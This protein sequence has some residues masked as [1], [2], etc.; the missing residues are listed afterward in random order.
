MA[1]IGKTPTPAP[2]TSSDIAADII[3]STHIGD[4][5]ISGF[6]AL[7][8]APADTDEFLI[9]DAGVLKRLDASLV[10]GG[11]KVLQVVTATASSTPSTTSSSFVTTG[12]SLSITPSA[13]SSK[14]FLIG[15][16][17]LQSTGNSVSVDIHQST[18]SSFVSGGLARGIG[19][20]EPANVMVSCS[21]NVLVSPNTTSAITYTVYFA[22]NGGSTAYYGRNDLL[23]SLTAFEIGA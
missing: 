16:F 6:D 3:N 21:A 19:A 18:S 12:H 14:I 4:T 1:Y 8:T 11:G 2:L 22:N 5:A 17:I 15:N 10:G 20:V 9:S 13:T 23:T 7:A